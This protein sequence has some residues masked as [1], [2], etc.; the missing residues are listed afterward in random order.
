M[1]K[2][3]ASIRKVPASEFAKNFGEYREHAQRE[4]LAVTSHGRTTGYFISS[5]HFEEYLR[6]RTLSRRAVRVVDLPEST[7]RAIANAR[8]DKKYDYLNKL[9]DD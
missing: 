6:L 1:K 5:E 7:I 9:L 4:P 2:R 3:P 8:M